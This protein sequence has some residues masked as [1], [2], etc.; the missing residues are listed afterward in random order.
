LTP[1]RAGIRIKTT[2]TEKEEGSLKKVARK[3][4]KR[5]IPPEE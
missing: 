5:K 3:K 4:R 1:W 2:R